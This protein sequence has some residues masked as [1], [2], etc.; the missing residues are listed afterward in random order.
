VVFFSFFRARANGT[1]RAILDTDTAVKAQIRNF[2]N[3]VCSYYGFVG[4]VSNA[5][6]AGSLEHVPNPD[7]IIFPI[8]GQQLGAVA[9]A[10][11][12]A[13]FLINDKRH[14]KSLSYG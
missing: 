13:V 1:G 2:C 14:D 10:A 5:G 4:A 7:L 3:A 6:A 11:F 12:S 9:G 8:N